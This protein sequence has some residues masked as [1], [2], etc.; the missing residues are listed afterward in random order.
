MAVLIQLEKVECLTHVDYPFTPIKDKTDP[1]GVVAR[2]MSSGGRG[3]NGLG[4]KT[5]SEEGILRSTFSIKADGNM[6][7]GRGVSSSGGG[8]AII[9]GFVLSTSNVLPAEGESG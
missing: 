3:D 8:R 4:G 6:L 7:V 5:P 1:R 2:C 9:S